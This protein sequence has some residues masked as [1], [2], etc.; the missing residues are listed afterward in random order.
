MYLTLPSNSSMEFFPNNRLNNFTTRLHSQID[1]GQAGT[2]E[3]GLC[4]ISYPH[5]WHNVLDPLFKR[6]VITTE[7]D[8]CMILCQDRTKPSE[9]KSH[10][11]Q[12]G[13]YKK[14]SEICDIYRDRLKHH[15]KINWDAKLSNVHVTLKNNHIL[16]L[17]ENMSVALGL[18]E[19]MVAPQD[20]KSTF[21]GQRVADVMPDIKS[22]YV[23]CD[24]I[25]D[26][27][28][29][30]SRVPLLRIV[31]VRGGHGDY[32]TKTYSNIQYLPT[33]GGQVQTVEIDI[34]DDTGRPIPF[35]PGRVIATL[36]LRRAR[37][38]YM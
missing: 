12:P 11:L 3:V 36:H 2:W 21:K 31:A 9:A 16:K 26:Q 8:W 34:R 37:S 30:D 18:P 38:H 1:L 33:K 20:R 27:Y 10:Y 35:Q 25:K 4:E 24:L 15:C 14:V 6:E 13:H 29:G 32:V 22:L 19:V 17:S 5:N 28:V 23:Y 7:E